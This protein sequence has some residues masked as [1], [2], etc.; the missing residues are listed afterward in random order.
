MVL[1]YWSCAWNGQYL[2]GIRHYIN[3]A[4]RTFRNVSQRLNTNERKKLN[5]GNFRVTGSRTGIWREIKTS[6]QPST[7]NSVWNE[8]ER[9]QPHF[10]RIC[11]VYINSEPA[12]AVQLAS[13]RFL[14][15]RPTCNLCQNLNIHLQF[16]I[17][18]AT[19]VQTHI[20]IIGCFGTHYLYFG[21]SRFES[22]CGYQLSWLKF[23][24]V[25]LIPSKQIMGF[26]LKLSNNLSAHITSK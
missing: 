11:H 1:P 17:T 5:G 12:E 7:R 4:E 3:R 14:F 2:T 22:R 18:C 20:V 13:R 10:E 16:Y 19:Y 6:F 25:F 8:T 21:G 23:I 9:C 24:V 26:Y 15:R